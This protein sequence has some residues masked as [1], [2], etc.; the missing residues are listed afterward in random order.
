MVPTGRIG[1]DHFYLPQLVGHPD[2]KWMGKEAVWSGSLVIEV[3]WL[4]REIPEL[5]VV[6]KLQFSLRPHPQQGLQDPLVV[7]R[8]QALRPQARELW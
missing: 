2:K 4:W 3:A 6:L 5:Q 8:G 7:F 1:T